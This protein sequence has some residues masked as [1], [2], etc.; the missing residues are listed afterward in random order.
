MSQPDAPKPK[1][2][3]FEGVQLEEQRSSAFL[4]ILGVVAIVGLVVIG[5]LVAPV[6]PDMWRKFNGRDPLYDPEHEP[7]LEA[8]DLKEIHHDLYGSWVLEQADMT[9]D[10]P[11]GL[12]HQ[13]REALAAALEPEPN[14]SALFGELAEHVEGHGLQTPQG[15]ERAL[16]LTRAWNQYL[17]Q[18]DAPYLLRATAEGE[19]VPHFFVYVFEVVGQGEVAVDGDPVRVRYASRIDRLNMWETF[20]GSEPREG[21]VVHADRLVQFATDVVWPLFAKNGRPS[22]MNKGFQEAVLAEAEG[23]LGA[24]V[25]AELRET[26]DLR[27]EAM[28]GWVDLHDRNRSCNVYGLRNLPWNGYDDAQLQRLGEVEGRGRCSPIRPTEL[29]LMQ[30][31]TK[32]FADRPGLQPAVEALVGWVGRSV[33]LREARR[34]ADAFDVAGDA[35]VQCT[36]CAGDDGNEVRAEVSAVL[37][38]WAWTKSPALTLFAA[39]YEPFADLPGPLLS[40]YPVATRRLLDKL[41]HSC[42]KGPHEDLNAAARAL[43]QNAYGRDAS[44]EVIEVPASLPLMPARE[45]IW[46]EKRAA[47][48]P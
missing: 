44:M 26:A 34:Y 2:R 25:V 46:A 18:H 33:S 48:E 15:R 36:F 22:K 31:V 5:V 17:D 42:S 30:R 47:E 20:E 11:E 7:N 43:A 16:W 38:E 41:E 24:D 32:T 37:G 1:R 45:R 13:Y 29:E 35:K 39:C 14:L 23:V 8:V 10:A 6:V 28:R 19:P 21:A 9:L 27:L 40:T 3:A 12:E 4:K